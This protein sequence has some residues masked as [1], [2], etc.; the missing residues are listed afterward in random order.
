MSA[1]REVA[2]ARLLLRPFRP[3]DAAAYGAIRAKPEVMR[4]MPGGIARCAT[5][6]SDAPRLVADFARQWETRGFGPWAVED[7]A[8]GALIGHL[9][10]RL[11]PELGGETEVLYLLDSTAWGRGLA[12][13]GALAARDEA[14]GR[15]GIARLVGYAMEANI[16]SRRV[17]EKIG[18]RPEGVVKVF[19]VEAVRHVLDAPGRRTPPRLS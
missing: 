18:M 14:F 8:T 6:E 17:L 1:P 5:A 9:G 7:R 3:E 15:L 19:G 2:T 11:L 4:F 13:E 12:T 16:A 10:L